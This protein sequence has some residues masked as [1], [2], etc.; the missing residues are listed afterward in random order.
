MIEFN[1]LK[2]TQNLVVMTSFITKMIGDAHGD[3]ESQA[4][5]NT[6]IFLI[7]VPMTSLSPF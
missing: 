5:P 1:L 4:T 7:L 3:L 6:N 2:S